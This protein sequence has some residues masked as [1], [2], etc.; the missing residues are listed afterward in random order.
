MFIT[1]NRYFVNIFLS[2]WFWAVFCQ[3]TVFLSS[4]FYQFDSIGKRVGL[5]CRTKV[6]LEKVAGMRCGVFAVNGIGSRFRF[7]VDRSSCCWSEKQDDEWSDIQEDSVVYLNNRWR[8]DW[9]PHARSG[10]TR[11]EILTLTYSSKSISRTPGKSPC[12]SSSETD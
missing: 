2:Y 4:G 12:F 11:R 1:E 9:F 5:R 10:V 6:D 8:A 3:S 7:N